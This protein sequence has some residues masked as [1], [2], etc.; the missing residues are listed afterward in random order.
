[1]KQAKPFVKWVGGK[2]QLVKE[3]MKYIPKEYNCYYEP[4]VG[5]G[6]VLF[7]LNPKRA[8]INDLNNELI[9][10]YRVIKDKDKHHKMCKLLDNYE[11]QNNEDFYYEIRNKDREKETLEGMQDYERAARTIYLN[12]ACFNGLYRVNSN[13]EFNVPYNKKAKI[14]TYDDENLKLVHEFL[15]SNNIEILSDDFEKVVKSA[16]AGDFVYFDPPY[17]NL[18]DSFTSY[19]KYGFGKKEQIRLFNLFKKLDKK[20]V[21]VMLSNHNTPFINDLYSDYK[22]TVV[23]ARRNVNSNGKGRGFVEETIITNY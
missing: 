2:R 16:K 19:T 15:N 23:K 20:G 5:G 6:A 11:K 10:A 1:M 22:I 3:I 21:K 4:F 14:N 17:D 12:K 9:N 7:A 18:N 8:V 13:G